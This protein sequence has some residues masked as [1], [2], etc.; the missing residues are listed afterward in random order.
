M[1]SPLQDWEMTANTKIQFAAIKLGRGW[2]TIDSD[3]RFTSLLWKVGSIFQHR[4]DAILL[5]LGQPHPQ[6]QS[7]ELFRQA[8]GMRQG[9]VCTAIAKARG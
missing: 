7:H 2:A 9:S 5:L 8:V 1:T 6:R 4:Q 3:Y